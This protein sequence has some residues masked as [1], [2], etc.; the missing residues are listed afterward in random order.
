MACSNRIQAAD[1]GLLDSIIQHRLANDE[2]GWKQLSKRVFNCQSEQDNQS[3]LLELQRFKLQ[4]DRAHLLES[5]MEVQTTEAELERERMNQ[6]CSAI[7]EQ[8]K[9]LLFELHQAQLDRQRK[10][11]YDALAY[12]IFKYPSR[13]DSLQ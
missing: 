1:T 10:M 13:D 11:E 3:A 8:N 9:Q 6:E 5:A 12:E 2:K 4:T 7:V